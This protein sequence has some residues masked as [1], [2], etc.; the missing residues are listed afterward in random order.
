MKQKFTFLMA[1]LCITVVAMAAQPQLKQQRACDV[2]KME[3]QNGK[4]VAVPNVAETNYQDNF[5][6]Y[7]PT[8]APRRAEG[9]STDSATVT[10]IY[11]LG[12]EELSTFYVW[13]VMVYNTEW[14]EIWHPYSTDGR[15]IEGIIVKV[16][17]GTYDIYTNTYEQVGSH[18]QFLHIDELIT[19]DKDTTIYLDVINSDNVM[20]WNLYDNNGRLLEPNTVRYLDQE[21]W[22]EVVDMGNVNNGQGEA[23]LSLDG[24]GFVDIYTFVYDSK[25]DEYPIFYYINELSDRY[26]FCIY[27]TTLDNDGMVYVN[28]LTDVGTGHFPLKNDAGD[29]VV[30]EEQIQRTPQGLELAENASVKLKTYTYINNT[31][32]DLASTNAESEDGVARVFINAVKNGDGQL[33][34]VNMAVSWGVIDYSGRGAAY[35]EGPEVMVTQNQGFECLVHD[36]YDA[37]TSE[38]GVLK[39]NYPP[40]SKFSYTYSQKKGIVGNSCPLNAISSKNQWEKWSNANMIMMSIKHNGRNGESIGSGNNYSRMTAK[41]NGEEVWNGKYALDSLSYSWMGKPDGAYEFEFTND[42]VGVDDI[43]GKNVTTVYFDQTKEDQNPPALKMLQFRDA[44]NNVTDRFDTPEGGIMMFAGGDFDPRSISYV[45]EEG[46]ESMWSYIECQP[47]TVEVSYAPYGTDEWLPLEGV[48]HQAEY[49]DIPGLGFF[50]SAPLTSVTTP[51]E[52]CWFDLKFRLVDEAGNWQEQTLSP[53]FRIEDVTQSAVTE[54][55]VDRATDNAIYNLAGQ[56]MR[57]DLNSLPHGIYITD[58]KKIVK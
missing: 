10:F 2:V 25:T 23:L 18:R 44:D 55:K 49:D 54:V 46:Y 30:Y 9:E 19:I 41:Y 5:S 16:P 51:S 6:L 24:Y 39:D 8:Q 52:N 17:F 38:V 28:R 37:Y 35:I 45:V 32:Y 20:C 58:G 21:P 33:D 7:S 42:N 36:I 53:A 34:G 1:M 27:E 22:V 26:K 29:Y 3:Q 31:L 50:Y 40:H 14:S 43:E 57:G 56:R 15:P 48:E 47:M 12:E 13:A 4:M 11:N